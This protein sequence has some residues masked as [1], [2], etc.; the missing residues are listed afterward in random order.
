MRSDMQASASVATLA[1]F[2]FLNRPETAVAVAERQLFSAPSVLHP[3]HP[4]R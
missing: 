2:L 1:S 3:L 4:L